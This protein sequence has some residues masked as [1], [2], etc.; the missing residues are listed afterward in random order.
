[1]R[2]RYPRRQESLR[3]VEAVRSSVPPAET[4][5]RTIA[6]LAEQLELSE[7]RCKVIA[8]QL[9]SV[10]I[11]ARSRGRVRMLREFAD[12]AEVESVLSAYEQRHRSDRE[13][14]E[15][16]MRYA[17]TAR[18]RMLHLREYFG[19]TACDDCNHCDNCRAHAQGLAA[20][21]LGES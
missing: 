13:R 4:G 1:M 2:G 17:Q 21:G 8:A 5:S 11:V 15:L 14:L 9:E 19:E 18:C 10:G 7:R 3:F 16:M 6:E 20:A 12:A